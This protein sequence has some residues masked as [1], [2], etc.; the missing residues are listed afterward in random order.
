[1]GRTGRRGDAR[2]NHRRARGSG[3]IA[4]RDKGG[5]SQLDDGRDK[6][7]FRHDV[8]ELVGVLVGYL[9]GPLHPETPEERAR[10]E[11]ECVVIEEEKDK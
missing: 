8:E 9:S 11:S 3:L 2:G 10:R 1:M 6:S 5:C 7:A 4:V